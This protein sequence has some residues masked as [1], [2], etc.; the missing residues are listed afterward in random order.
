VQRADADPVADLVLPSLLPPRELIVPPH[1]SFAA[2][3]DHADEDEGDGDDI[4]A[5]DRFS[6][7]LA[8]APRLEAQ[9]GPFIRTGEPPALSVIE[10]VVVFPGQLAG[11]A[12]VQ[13]AAIRSAP[14]ADGAQPDQD[15]TERA[16]R[17]ALANLQ[18]MSGTA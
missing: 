13:P 5:D 8:L 11:P 2:I 15:E 14:L 10:P 16:L 4:S 17:Q 18:R 1:A 3:A 6:S 12:P 7:L 9:R